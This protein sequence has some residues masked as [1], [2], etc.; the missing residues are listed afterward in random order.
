MLL[1]SSGALHLRGNDPALLK[2]GATSQQ[3]AAQDTNTYR[4]YKQPL[5][6]PDKGVHQPHVGVGAAGAARLT[7]RRLLQ[8][9]QA[10]QP[11]QQQVLVPQLLQQQVLV[12]HPVVFAPQQVQ[13]PAVLYQPLPAVSPAAL[14][15]TVPQVPVQSDLLLQQ[16]FQQFLASQQ[17]QQAQQQLFAGGTAAT[18][19]LVPSSP[20]QAALPAAASSPE[21]RLANQSTATTAA[22]VRQAQA[23]VQQAASAKAVSVPAAA[24]A[25]AAPT[26][27]PLWPNFSQQQIQQ[28]QQQQQ[29]QQYQQQQQQYQQ[30]QQA[31]QYQQF[32]QFQQFLQFQQFQAWLASQ[33][34]QQVLYPPPQ[35][36]LPYLQPYQYPPA[37]GGGAV[38]R[39]VLEASRP[40]D[41]AVPIVAAPPAATGGGASSWVG[42]GITINISTP[43]TVTN[44]ITMDSS[45]S[46]KG[47]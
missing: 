15:Y 24:P 36:Q 1:H 29:Q 39:P 16:Q 11:M 19:Q 27:S 12:P 33:Q 10:G 7:A 45:S 14:S 42:P 2:L 34:Y 21:P 30:Q 38:T 9:W 46:N 25:G 43:V 37:T 28:L 22:T 8:T 18:Q 40:E 31:L 6:P 4:A 47:G 5:R 35:Q 41:Q 44:P 17:Q 26:T 3:K 32:Q 20:G 13:Q 23:P